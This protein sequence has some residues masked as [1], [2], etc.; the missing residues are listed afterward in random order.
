MPIPRAV[1]PTATTSQTAHTRAE[2]EARLGFLPSFF[3]PALTAPVVLNR[4]WRLTRTAYLDNPLPAELKQRLIVHVSRLRS[5]SYGVVIHS[6]ELRALGLSGRELLDVLQAPLGGGP[7][8]AAL[9]RGGG[10]SLA[11]W[12]QPGSSDEARIVALATHAFAHDDLAEQ[13]VAELRRL[14]GPARYERL[15]SL[16]SYIE[17][18][19]EWLRAHPEISYADDPRVRRHL[20]AMLREEPL[21]RSLLDIDGSVRERCARTLERAARELTS[22][23]SVETTLHAVLEALGSEMGWSY[24][25]VWIPTRRYG[26]TPRLRCATSW[27]GGQGAT[28]FAD[29][30]RALRLDPGDGLPARAWESAQTRWI[31]DVTADPHA[32]CAAEAR[33]DGLRGCYLLPVRGR[34][35]VVA[36]LELLSADSRRP[37]PI[38][39]ETL[40]VLAAR[41][42]EHLEH[43]GAQP[44]PLL[45]A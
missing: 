31:A 15:A 45:A 7:S 25:A 22:D 26:G 35:G 29:A 34:D 36:L 6:C 21:L 9:L 10:G 41:I 44:A 18:C 42:G 11:G 43:R 3:A 4:L 8:S 27:Q 5:C 13:C 30:N 32:T 23:E 39:L 1:P 37:D 40:D 33:Q 12:P 2:I 24:A 38:A 19:D 28:A 17:T 20:P 14:L 16:L